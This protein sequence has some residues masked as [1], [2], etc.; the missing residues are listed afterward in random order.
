[1]NQARAILWAQWRTM[2]NYYPRE[3]VGWGV[4]IGIIWYGIWA[5]AALACARLI[6]NPDSAGLLKALLPGGL[7]IVF[8]YWQVVPVLMAATGASLEL[9]K[10]KVYP[11]PPQQLFGI[12]VMLRVTAGIEMMM[13]LIGV[14][15]GVLFNPQLPAWA[16]LAIFPYILFNLFLAVGVRDL[17]LRLLSR[18]RVREVVVFALVML[19]ALPRLMLS[20]GPAG[21]KRIAGVF[22][23]DSWIGF[24]WA[25]AAA[26]LQG[27]DVFNSAAILTMWTLCAALF[28]RWQFMRTMAFD[29][30]AAAAGDSKPQ[31][32]EGLLQRFYRFPSMLLRDPLGALVEKDI[33]FLAR[34]SRFRLVFLMGFTFGVVVIPIS[35]G[36]HRDSLLRDHYL[37]AVSVYSL[38]LL[39]ESCFWNSFGF[40]RSAAQVYFL[41]PVSF[42]RVLIGKNLSALFYIALEIFAITLVCGIVGM[43]LTPGLLAEAYSVAGVVTLFLLAAGNLMSVRNARGVNPNTQ[44]RKN[45][46]GRVQALLLFVY[47]IAFVPVGLAYLAQWAL[48]SELAFFG[49]LALDAALA[50]VIYKLALESAVGMAERRKEEMIAALSAGDG[51]IGG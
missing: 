28:G 40:D 44:F 49:V 14:G 3:G 47:P 30:E 36:G 1:M 20:F 11:I 26:W 24:P 37:T 29:A 35:M 41:A 23:G 15:F 32:R 38:V 39:S 27:A 51:I 2:R 10:L 33:R 42:T 7:L 46:A 4:L 22:A 34:S 43:H 25:S 5:A 48:D 45:A 19:T 6:A 31:Q 8:L 50:A 18:K 16:A 9:K 21:N 13:V 12:E 17:L